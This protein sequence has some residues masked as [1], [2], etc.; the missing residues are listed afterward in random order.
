MAGHGRAAGQTRCR[1]SCA[2]HIG[3][4]R[5]VRR[6]AAGA[7]HGRA[8][9]RAGHSLSSDLNDSALGN[10]RDFWLARRNARVVDA[11]RCRFSVGLLCGDADLAKENCAGVGDAAS[12]LLSA[13]K[14]YGAR[15]RLD[16]GCAATRVGGVRDDARPVF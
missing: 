13:I 5:L 6:R 12:E 2:I 16:K 15:G 7:G 4:V 14:S 10:R 3:F 8:A 11:R 1:V 9:L